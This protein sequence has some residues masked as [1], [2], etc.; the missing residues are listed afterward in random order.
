MKLTVQGGREIEA[1]LKDLGGA[2]AG[3]LGNNATLAG[4]R[5]ID[6]AREQRHVH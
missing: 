5:V 2:I 4:A 1:K 3:R 6:A